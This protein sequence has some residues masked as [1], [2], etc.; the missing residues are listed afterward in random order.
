MSH[1][2]WQESRWSWALAYTALGLI[3]ISLTLLGYLFV[4]WALGA[5]L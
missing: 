3:G 5:I 1:I 4:A 2:D